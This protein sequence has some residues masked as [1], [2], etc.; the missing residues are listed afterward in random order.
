MN[1]IIENVIAGLIVAAI[2]WGA[3]RAWSRFHGKEPTSQAGRTRRDERSGSAGG[4]ARQIP[5][6]PSTRGEKPRGA[7]PGAWDSHD[8]EP[9]DGH[10]VREDA[11]P[12]LSEKRLGAADTDDSQATGASRK[13]RRLRG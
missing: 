5:S 9:G 11:E 2:V 1:N 7:V 6:F 13:D 8:R 10:M 12:V 3:A 4:C